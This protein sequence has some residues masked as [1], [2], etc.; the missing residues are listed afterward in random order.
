M[1]RAPSSRTAATRRGASV[2]AA[3]CCSAC[4]SAPASTRSDRP[5]PL[6]TDWVGARA[7]PPATAP[8]LP[9]SPAEG[10]TAPVAG[11]GGAAVAPWVLHVGD[12]FVH[13]FLWQTLRPLFLADHTQYV[14]Q[15]ATSTYTTTWASSPELE[16]WLARRPALVIVT[17]G[18]NEADM[19]VPEMHARAVE[20]LA[21]KIAATGASCVWVTPPMWKAENGIL[22]VIHDHCAPCI[23]FDSDAVLGG[24]TK[25]ERQSDRIH[26]NRRGGERWAHAFWQWLEE[27]RDPSRGPWALD[28]FERRG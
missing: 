18:A 28:P 24:L 1:R 2:V 13:A 8:A 22:D 9:G 4:A 21:R 23:F 15:A 19:T 10:A 5:A 7:E 20:T 16:E 25:E 26:P 11:D 3:I 17:L 6:A 14:V 27:H 12:S